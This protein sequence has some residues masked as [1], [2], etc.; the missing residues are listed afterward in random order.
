MIMKRSYFKLFIVIVLY[1]SPASY[2]QN[3][4]KLAWDANSEPDFYHYY[5]YRNLTD[6]AETAEMIASVLKPDITYTD[7]SVVPGTT[8]YYWATAVDSSGNESGCS[9]GASGVSVGIDT[10]PPAP[11]LNF[12]VVE[13]QP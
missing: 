11:P 5:I 3:K 2:S 7:T 1:W 10:I 13:E 6:N 4:I 8:Y 12:R 9:N